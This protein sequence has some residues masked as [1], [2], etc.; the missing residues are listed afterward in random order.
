M[1][2]VMK[3]LNEDEQ[4]QRR[5]WDRYAERGYLQSTIDPNDEKGL[6]CKYI[7]LWS[8][9][10]L[11]QFLP[12]N[13]KT[14][15]LEVGCGSGRNLFSLAPNV[16]MAFG[17]DVSKKQIINAKRWKKEKNVDNIFFFDDVEKLFMQSP[18][19]GCLFTMWILQGF[20]DDNNLL[21]MIQ[22]YKSGLPTIKTFVFFEQVATQSYVVKEKSRFYKK[23]RTMENYIQI[24]S[25]A[26]LDLR[27]YKILNEKGFGPL[28]KYIYMT[29]LYWYW[30]RWMDINNILFFID[31]RLVKRQIADTFTDVVFVCLRGTNAT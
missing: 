14:I 27:A 31:R 5:I 23:I 3:Y 12:I 20:N 18:D 8:Q 16:K 29:R 11:R 10:Y 1:Y 13:K 17:T 7:D 24:F 15:F 9:H 26:G 21:K 30:P 19:I 4:N 28:Y 25:Q 6:K 22:M 2:L